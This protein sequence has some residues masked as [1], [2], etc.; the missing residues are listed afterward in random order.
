MN[1][2]KRILPLGMALLI[3]MPAFGGGL[4]IS[5]FGQPGM[6]LSGAGWNVLAEDAS[7]GVANPAGIFWMESDSEWMVAG[8]YVVT[9]D[10]I[11]S[12]RGYND[13]RK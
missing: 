12:G 8:M 1:L 3:S 9:F 4:Y 11:S 6:G 13:P 2:F 7:T 5:E 10:E